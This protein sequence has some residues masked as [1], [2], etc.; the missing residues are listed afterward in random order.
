MA[1]KEWSLLMGMD[2]GTDRATTRRKN[3][4]LSW[5]G[6][7]SVICSHTK[8]TAV[9]CLDADD[10]MNPLI[11]SL[12]CRVFQ[13]TSLLPTHTDA[14][15]Q[16]QFHATKDVGTPQS[17]GRMRRTI[18]LRRY[19]NDLKLN[20]QSNIRSHRSNHFDPEPAT[21]RQTS[22]K[23]SRHTD[24]DHYKMPTF[25]RKAYPSSGNFNSIGER[26]RR[27]LRTRPFLMFGLPF[28][29]TMV[30]GSFFLT[31]ATAVRYEKHDRKTHMLDTQTALGLRGPA[32]A[33][34]DKGRSMKEK[35]ELD[36]LGG[37]KGG[38]ASGGGLKGVRAASGREG[39]RGD[40]REEYWVSLAAVMRM[41]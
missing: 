9:S 8:S 2:N 6:N 22:S 4:L 25:A 3:L 17:L 19:K 39:V 36:L 41:S 33:G 20:L 15:A 29:G 32:D 38:G 31:P 5:T 11:P 14:L 23:A 21:S 1:S 37:R 24:H 26:Y 28:V 35:E 34:D 30:A 12:L 18:P 13:S 10:L 40:I 16:L 7:G 27:L